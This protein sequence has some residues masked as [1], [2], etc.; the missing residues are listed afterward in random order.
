MEVPV[1]KVS[2]PVIK[3]SLPVIKEELLAR[4]NCSLGKDSDAMIAVDHHNFGV[5]VGID[6]VVCKTD[7]VTLTR[8]IHYEIYTTKSHK[9]V[10][11][12]PKLLTSNANWTTITQT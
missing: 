1:I 7:L 12:Q 3:V 11:H 10:P 5:A 9:L 2:L 8:C 6:R 4:L